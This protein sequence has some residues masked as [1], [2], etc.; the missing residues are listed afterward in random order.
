MSINHEVMKVKLYRAMSQMELEQLLL[1][2][3]FAAGP[4]SLEVK[5]FAE[6][7]EDAVKWG[8]LLLGKGNYRMV[9]INISS[10]VAD[11]FLCWEKLDGIGPARCAELE[12]LKDFTVR[13]IL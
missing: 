13:I 10:Q 2:G 6:R 12:Q 1:T 7:F 5:F 11:S 3:E 8:D 9:E 4:N